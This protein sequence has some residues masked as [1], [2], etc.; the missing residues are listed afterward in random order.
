M[1]SMFPKGIFTESSITSLI[2]IGLV[3]D[4]TYILYY[5]NQ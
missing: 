2:N 5:S 3:Y 4:N 1:S